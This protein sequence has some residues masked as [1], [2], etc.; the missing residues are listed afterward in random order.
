MDPIVSDL[1]KLWKLKFI[2]ADLTAVGCDLPAARKIAGFLVIVLTK[3]VQGAIVNFLM[4]LR[5]ITLVLIEARGHLEVMNTEKML[6]KFKLF[7]SKREKKIKIW[8]SLFH[9]I[10]AHFDPIKMLLI[11]PMHNLFLSELLN[12]FHDI[13]YQTRPS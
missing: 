8:L 6:Q 11:D 4:G 13:I 1:N 5:T 7:I 9:F 3:D 2:H 12:T 10:N